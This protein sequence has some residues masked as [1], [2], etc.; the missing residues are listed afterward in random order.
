V[1]W[2][3][4]PILPTF[5]R[6][7][8]RETYRKLAKIVRGE[9]PELLSLDE[10]RKRLR[11]FEQSYVGIVPIRVDQIVGS[12]D[13][14]GDFER[15]FLPKTLESRERSQDIERAF[16][17]GDFPPIVVYQVGDVF[18]VVDGHHRVAAANQLGTEY[19]DA[20]VTRLKS[21]VPLDAGADVAQ[22]IH[23]EQQQIFLEETGLERARPEARVEFSR[24]DGYVELLELVKVHGYHVMLHEGEV[25]RPDEIAQLWWDTVYLPAVEVIHR[26]GLNEV[27]A[28]STDADLFLWVH[29]RRRA[30]FPE[31]GGMSFEEAARKATRERDSRVPIPKRRPRG[32]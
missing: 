4:F 9:G 25:L 11:L 8:R 1:G 26:E 29:Q 15:D 21:R 30:F 6:A 27:F 3:R 20:E 31:L 13:R 5:E 10:T 16:P 23:A 17:L 24:P 19:I 18:F 22:L 12:A 14:A 28:K 2:D 7:R 32:S